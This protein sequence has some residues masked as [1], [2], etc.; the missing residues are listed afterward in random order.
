M[1]QMKQVLKIQTVLL[2]APVS[3]GPARLSIPSPP[4]SRHQDRF[5]GSDPIGGKACEKRSKERTSKLG[6]GNSI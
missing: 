1:R 2:A 5:K 3:A 6:R 4:K